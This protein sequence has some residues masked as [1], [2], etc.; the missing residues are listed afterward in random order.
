[1]SATKNVVPSITID[2]QQY[3]INVG[4][5]VIRK[6]GYPAYICILESDKQHTIAIKPCDDNV[7]PSFKV[8]EGFPENRQK[9]FRIYSQGLV[10]EIMDGYGLEKG[11]RYTLKGELDE[12]INGVVF[13]LD[14]SE[15][16]SRKD[17]E[18]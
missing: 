14:K 18:I 15:D 16:C 17:A 6:L 5:D 13:H 7:M 12:E 10:L 3:C 8:P 4:R 1:M 2:G 11:R 9:K